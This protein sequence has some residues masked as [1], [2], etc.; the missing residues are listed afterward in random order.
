VAALRPAE[1]V[2][3][4]VLAHSVSKPTVARSSVTG[5]RKRPAR[6]SPAPSVPAATELRAALLGWYDAQARDLPWRRTRDPYAIWVS[7]V[8]LQQTQVPVVLPYW[9][10]FM[11]RFP[12]VRTLAR[13]SLDEVLAAWRGLGY[14]ARAR[15]LHRSAQA[16]VERHAGRLPDEVE[17]LRALPGFGRYT[18]GA[19]ASIAFG[20]EVPLV[21]GNVAR[22]LA[23]LFG[24]AGATGDA[25]REQRLWALA[26]VLVRGPRPGDWNQALMELGATVCRSEQPTCLLCPLRAHCVGLASGRVA[27]I[28]A[29]KT[30]APRRTLHIALAAVRRG[31]AVLLVRREGTGLFGGLWE[32]PGVE[33][34]AGQELEALRAR[35]PEIRR[36]PRRLGRVERTLTHR[37]LTLEIFEVFGLG[38]PA[39]GRWATREEIESLGV[40][41]AMQAV[42]RRVLDGTEGDRTW[43]SSRPPRSRG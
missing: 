27:E 42:L 17:A 31:E 15:N 1:I 43:R 2:G 18:V 8:M 4:D 5:E 40:S 14:Y 22:V 11:A 13:A 24:V 37:A 29:P 12:D 32:L 23:R 10:A 20:R 3:E 25:A 21:D 39:G 33:C 19:V 28:P 41:S 6:R 9:T 35:W 30:R 26:E 7:E 16:V 38:P 36:S 34:A